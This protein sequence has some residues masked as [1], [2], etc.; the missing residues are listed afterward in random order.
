MPRNSD[1]DRHSL[2]FERSDKGWRVTAEGRS[3][4]AAATFLALIYMVIRPFRLALAKW[5]LLW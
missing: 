2:E 4:V 3:G 5:L 1:F